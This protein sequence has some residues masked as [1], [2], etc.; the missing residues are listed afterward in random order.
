M[1]VSQGE[2][3]CQA[4][5]L[6]Q[7]GIDIE[8]LLETDLLT[9]LGFSLIS[10]HTKYLLTGLSYNPVERSNQNARQDSEQSLLY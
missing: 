3:S 9:K 8:V 2:H 1:N 7:K 10:D 6:V 5:M 4:V